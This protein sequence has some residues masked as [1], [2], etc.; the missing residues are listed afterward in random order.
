MKTNKILIICMSLH[1]VNIA[2]A[3]QAAR[4]AFQRFG[5]AGRQLA[6]QGQG[7][8]Q[9]IKP[10]IESG[11][12]QA[13][14]IIPS[15]QNFFETASQR[16]KQ[17]GQNLEATRAEFNKQI[18]DQ[19]QPGRQRFQNYVQPNYNT[20]APKIQTNTVSDSTLSLR[21]QMQG[22]QEGLSSGLQ[23]I[24]SKLGNIGN[25]LQ[26]RLRNAGS[27]IADTTQSYS[28]SLRNRLGRLNPF[29]SKSTPQGDRFESHMRSPIISYNDI[30]L[31][32]VNE[33]GTSDSQAL[34]NYLEDIQTAAQENASDRSLSDLGNGYLGDLSSTMTGKYE[35]TTL[36]PK[37]L[38]A[39]NKILAEMAENKILA[40]IA[41]E[42]VLLDQKQ[43]ELDRLALVAAQLTGE[44]SAPLLVD[45]APVVGLDT[46]AESI[47]AQTPKVTLSASDL[48]KVLNQ[49]TAYHY[50]PAGDIIKS[51]EE[52]QNYQR[53]LENLPEGVSIPHINVQNEL[54]DL[55][56]FMRSNGGSYAN[57]IMSLGRTTR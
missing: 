8:L 55:N 32:A 9:R 24:R 41:E 39:G 23:S 56:Q 22:T 57:A 11:M 47:K 27:S 18:S 6:N 54:Q 53:I 43:A 29:S 49:R 42:Q 17:F 48:S 30:N 21:E 4:N 33:L 12:Q 26:S 25:G 44:S 1:V 40:E 5:Q 37:G 38:L 45:R 16:M 35:G 50:A 46:V 34:L 15:G 28:S 20:Q 13:Q 3:A 7:I 36:S 10:T 51:F 52:A 19:L 2:Q 31:A 14:E